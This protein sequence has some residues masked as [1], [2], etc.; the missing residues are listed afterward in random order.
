MEM[1]ENDFMDDIFG[2]LG[3]EE[4]KEEESLDLEE[5]M[6]PSQAK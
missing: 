6:Q 1:T 2:E 3:Y 4:G 5:M